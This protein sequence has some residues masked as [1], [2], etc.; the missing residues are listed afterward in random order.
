MTR[1]SKRRHGKRD[2]GGFTLLELLTALAVLG[3]AVTVFF[4]L[5][6]ASKS[7]AESSLTHE[8]AADLAREYLAS[9]RAHPEQFD[10]PNFDV[11]AVGESQDLSAA[12]GSDLDD[13][14]AQP[15]AAMPTVRR[16]Y[17]RERSLYQDFSWAASAR[18]PEASARYV[19]VTVEIAW[20][21]KGHPRVFALTTALPR[22]VVE[23][24]GS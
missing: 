19:E 16:P 5:F 10:W 24:A 11:A 22:S 9:I 6:L 20:T 12:E 1:W 4:Q 15:P 13:V 21:T 18:L 2:R 23:G 8:V 17:D 3:I 7:L 14:F